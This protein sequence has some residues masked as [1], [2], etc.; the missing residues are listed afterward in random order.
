MIVQQW[1]AV[2]TQLHTHVSARYWSLDVWLGLDLLWDIQ[3]R[4]PAILNNSLASYQSPSLPSMLR[5]DNNYVCH[6][7][8]HVTGS[9]HGNPNIFRCT[10][11]TSDWSP[12]PKFLNPPLV[13]DV[14]TEL[15]Q[16][17]W[18]EG[19]GMDKYRQKTN[20]DTMVADNNDDKEHQ[21]HGYTDCPNNYS[22]S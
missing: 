13:H 1:H 5:S 21:I 15:C 7:C 3:F 9:E 8:I 6:E 20:V 18:P 14:K 19:T 17:Y 11:C 4:L 2:T 10:S 22:L 16:T 12:I